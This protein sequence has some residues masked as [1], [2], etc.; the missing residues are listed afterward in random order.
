MCLQDRKNGVHLRGEKQ[1]CSGAALGDLFSYHYEFIMI[2]IPSSCYFRPIQ[3]ADLF[4]KATGRPPEC[5]DIGAYEGALAGH[6]CPA[7]T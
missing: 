5:A 6:A 4:S 2:N 7:A 3:C 1:A